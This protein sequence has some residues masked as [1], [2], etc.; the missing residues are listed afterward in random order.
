MMNT[1]RSLLR[2]FPI[3]LVVLFLSACGALNTTQVRDSVYDLPSEP[4]AQVEPTAPP[5][6][7]EPEPATKQDDYY[8]EDESKRYADP[9]S[10]YDMTYND[11]YYYNY[12]RFGFGMGMGSYGSGFGMNYGYGNSGYGGW[13]D[14]YWNNSWQSGYG[15]WGSNGWN[16]GFGGYGGYGGGYGYGNCWGCSSWNSGWG[17][18]PYYGYGGNCYGCY[19]P[20]I[21]WNGD[22]GSGSVV[23]HRSNISGVRPGSGGDLSSSGNRTVAY[24]PVGLQDPRVV[25]EHQMPT[26]R[27]LPADPGSRPMRPSTERPQQHGR[28]D[29]PNRP[30]FETRPQGGSMDQ[31]TRPSG[32]GGRTDSPSR[33]GGNRR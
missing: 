3:A 18:G 11:P 22:V 24:N 17:Y 33:S 23:G 26:T 8:N 12:G 31:G 21:I 27:A 29:R 13:N 25:R 4:V 20:I 30:S 7:P 32:G 1:R 5:A 16:N 14:P 2:T 10:Y 28:E 19:Q 9:R 6:E 15:A